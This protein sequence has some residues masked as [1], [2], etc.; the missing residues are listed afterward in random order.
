[1]SLLLT[2]I[3]IICTGYNLVSLPISADHS[4]DFHHPYRIPT[5]TSQFSHLN[6]ISVHQFLKPRRTSVPL[7]IHFSSV[8]TLLVVLSGDINLNPG[9]S[10]SNTTA[11]LKFFPV[12]GNFNLN[13]GP[14]S[15]IALGTLNIRSLF[16]LNRPGAITGLLHDHDIH[17]LALS[18]TWQ[19][20]TK[21]TPAQVNDITPPGF[22]FIGQPSTSTLYKPP[23]KSSRHKDDTSHGG[24]GFL[25]RDHLKTQR[26]TLSTYTSFESLAITFKL[27][28]GPITIFNIYRPPENSAYWRPFTTFLSEFSAFLSL[29]TTTPHAYIITGDFNI[30]VNDVTD[31]KSQQFQQLLQSHSLQQH[32]SFPTHNEGNTL[33]LVITPTE[34]SLHPAVTYSPATPSDHYLLLT[35]LDAT[36]PP[37]NP[38]TRRTYRRTSSINIISFISDISKSSLITDPP[39]SLDDLVACYNSTLR[40]ILDKHAPLQTKLIRPIKSS[41]WFTP[42]VQ[43]L[44]SAYR[45]LERNWKSCKTPHTLQLLRTASNAYHRSILAA[46]RLYHSNLIASNLTDSRKLWQTINTILHRNP[47]KS[48]PS[49]SSADPAETAQSFSSFF[50]DKIIRL[51]SAIPPT[52][53]SP[54]TP[55][56][57]CAP[58]TFSSFTP[59]TVD[60]I[61]RL[62]RSAPDKQCDLDPIPT[63]LL[64]KCLP[65]LAP[66]ITNIV[67]ISLASGKFPSNFKESIVTP[68]I[69]KPSLDPDNLSNY[70]PISNL[71]YLSKLT[72]RVVKERLQ[73]HLSGNSLFNI[74]Q[75]AYTK[76]HS[77]ETALLSL[78][79]HLIRATS[80]QHVTCLCLLD[81]SAAFDTIDHTILLKRLTHWFGFTDTALSWFESYLT[82]RSFSVLSSGHKSTSTPL[83]CGVP[84][85]SVLGPLLFIMYT[86]PLSTLLSGTSVD[87]HL[88]ADDTQLFISFSP[89]NFSSSVNQLQSVFSSVSTWMSANLLSLNPS[90]T[91]FLVIGLP[92][93]LAKINNPQLVI[94]PNTVLA[95]ASHARNLGFLIDNNLTLNQQISALSRSCSYHLRDLRRIR[96]TLDFKTASTIA[97]SLVQSKLDYCNSLYLNLPAYHITKLQVIQNNMARAV[98]SKRKFDRITPT[99]RSLHW[100]KIEQRIQ[101]KIISLTYTALQ[102]GQPHYLR[103]LLIVQPG[104]TR[105][106]DI[107]TLSRPA[108]SRLKISDR[109]FHLK[110]PAIW[111]SLPAHLRQPTSPTPSNGLGLLA[112]SRQQFLAQLKTHLFHQSFPPGSQ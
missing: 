60:E 81:L 9:P 85:G 59:A 46:K 34:S 97:T 110:A 8:V 103:C 26:P 80:R 104:P 41:P 94:D 57:P 73:V 19:N 70:R 45:R 89:H 108:T 6:S 82:S 83:T 98:T 68:L 35:S 91:E 112:L 17:I 61:M 51:Q 7:N 100:L 47:V 1:M 31:S 48:V 30:H 20:P 27:A 2:F 36:P 62:I 67:N 5:A 15:N 40:T 14:P 55:D 44:K 88:Y 93:Q 69:K 64:K 86:T 10:S 50:S 78:Y 49:N 42:A 75:S 43:V 71:S 106:G 79:D 92:Q 56:P 74:F 38:A 4:P 28:A 90:K 22:Q 13:S 24:L 77:T 58:A 25:Y 96:T 12:S 66:T 99:L 3:C 39:D 95:P 101:Y 29:A 18:E 102:T 54:H 84:Q 37:P 11:I 76:F 63:S 107:I 23:P 109:S 16:A 53:S 21:T 32:V 105:S 87:H 52:A 33:D 72:E 65:V 111:N